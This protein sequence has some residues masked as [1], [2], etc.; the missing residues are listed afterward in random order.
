MYPADYGESCKSHKEPGAS[1]CFDITLTVPVE[2]TGS[3][4]ASWCDDPWCYVDP[5]ACAASDPTASDY[6]PAML[7]YSYATCGSAN[8]YVAAVGSS[9]TVGDAACVGGGS[10]TSTGGDVTDAMP[11]GMM[12]C[13]QAC[14][15]I[16]KMSSSE[17]SGDGMAM[18]KM[19]E[20]ILACTEKNVKAC[21]EDVVKY[22]TG[23]H[24][25]KQMCAMLSGSGG[26]MPAMDGAGMEACLAAC[27][28]MKKLETA[29][30]SD[31]KALC[32]M[33]EP[34]SE[35]GA[36][37]AEDCK[38]MKGSIDMMMIMCEG[39]H[40]GHDHAEG[41]E[42]DDDMAMLKM[43]EP[44]IAKCPTVGTMFEIT[45]RTMTKDDCG[46]A[47]TAVTCVMEN[48]A[49]DCAPVVTIMMEDQDTLKEL[50]TVCGIDPMAA[51]GGGGEATPTE[52]DATTVTTTTTAT[53][54]EVSFTVKGVALDE[55]SDDDKTTMKGNFA[56]SVAKTAGVSE[57]KVTVALVAGSIV[58]KSTIDVD[59]PSQATALKDTLAK[60]EAA[61]AMTATAKASPVLK[62]ALEAKGK[63]IDDLEVTAPTA[64]TV[65]V[66][67]PPKAPPADATTTAGPTG[68][69]AS[70]AETVKAVPV[71]AM[72]AASIALFA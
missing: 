7:S 31:T 22:I 33:V 30:M 23:G 63:T 14:P 4:K 39:G 67:M 50:K 17:P 2:K 59:D 47:Q 24:D 26:E 42:H 5:C 55:L 10:M 65:T 36:K 66:T 60:P 62:K 45:Q 37:N 54:V 41:G 1:A 25:M 44:C 35:C 72:V 20:P 11:A 28:D 38:A 43:A 48:A 70:L 27:P 32:A 64:T 3:D 9:M 15:V 52:P 53:K 34:I 56:K 29:D 69:D 68:G 71:L 19:F 58:V 49:G 21:G 57:D 61:A 8:A 6:F 46:T 18:C 13:M 40:D 51:A 16:E 12:E